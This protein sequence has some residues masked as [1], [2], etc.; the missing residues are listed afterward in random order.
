MKK[1]LALAIAVP[2]VLAGCSTPAAY[3]VAVD[4]ANSRKTEIALAKEQTESA[5]IQALTQLAATGDASART[6]AVMAL[7]FA[8]MGQGKQANTDMVAPAKPDGAGDTMLKWTSVL[9][10]SL[11]QFYA[12]GKNA[13]VSIVNSNNSLEGQKSNNGMVVDLVQGRIPPVIGN[14]TGA[15]G[16]TEDFLLYPR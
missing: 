6:A 14:R 13:E 15:D 2:L 5:R 1:L 16:S 11:T 12:I 7:A 9:L 10:P 3:Y 4:N 8:N